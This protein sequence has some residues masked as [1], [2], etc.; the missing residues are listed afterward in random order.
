VHVF[1]SVC[2]VYQFINLHVCVHVCEWVRVHARVYV[3]V[4]VCVCMYVCACVRV[5][6]RMC[7]CVCARDIECGHTCTGA[8]A[9]TVH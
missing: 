9:A 5:R 8:Q 2:Q 7:V 1:R 3:C 6:V 4:C